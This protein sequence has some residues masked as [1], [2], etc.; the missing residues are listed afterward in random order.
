MLALGLNA[1]AFLSSLPAPFFLNKYSTLMLSLAETQLIVSTFPTFHSQMKFL[2]CLFTFYYMWDS[3]GF[4]SDVYLLERK[5]WISQHK[6]HECSVKH[7]MSPF[8]YSLVVFFVFLS[9]LGGV[10]EGGGLHEAYR[11]LS[12]Y[13]RRVKTNACVWQDGLVLHSQRSFSQMC[14]PTSHSSGSRYPP[15]LRGDA[16]VVSTAWLFS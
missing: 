11:C 10:L 2:K 5:K 4:L 14:Q 13:Q 8:W 1:G 7:R 15:S 9:H 3:K 6:P 16:S 12:N